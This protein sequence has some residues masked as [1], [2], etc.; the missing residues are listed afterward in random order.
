MPMYEYYCSECR[1]NF[2]SF[3]KMVDYL[4]P[5]PHTCGTLAQKLISKPMIAVDYPAYESPATGKWITGR[6]EHEEDL[7][8]SGC[9]LL[10]PGEQGDAVNRQ[11][12]AD[13]KFEQSID[14]SVETVFAEL[15]G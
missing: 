11:K 15:K 7:K 10:E 9:R 6:R 3:K 8:R 1:V 4:E 12:A 2:D 14:H 13:Q 5:Q